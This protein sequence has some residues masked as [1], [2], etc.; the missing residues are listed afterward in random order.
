VKAAVQIRDS[1]WLFIEKEARRTGSDGCTGVSDWNIECCWEHDL[2]CWSNKNPRSAYEQYLANP[3]ADPDEWWTNAEWMTRRQADYAFG[4]CNIEWSHT[5][6]GKVRSFF[7][8]IGSRIGAFLGIGVRKPK[9]LPS[10][11]KVA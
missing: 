3:T 10:V 5:K 2:A 9:E 7:R 8:F 6:K 4:A 11:R 1:Y